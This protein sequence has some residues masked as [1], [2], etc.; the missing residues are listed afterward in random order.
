MQ[1]SLSVASNESNRVKSSACWISAKR[2][3]DCGNPE[4]QPF[5]PAREIKTS[6]AGLLTD[7]C[8][9]LRRDG[10]ACSSVFQKRILGGGACPG[11]PKNPETTADQ[12]TVFSALR[13]KHSSTCLQ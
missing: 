2:Y 10:P 4:D 6:Q 12:L 9:D 7:V 11:P 13:G 3:A 1:K 5:T 8:K